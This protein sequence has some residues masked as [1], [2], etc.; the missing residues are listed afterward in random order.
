L[1][2]AFR[3]GERVDQRV[4]VGKDLGTLVVVENEAGEQFRRFGSMGT[5]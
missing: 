2:E 4:V 1:F 3:G 5:E